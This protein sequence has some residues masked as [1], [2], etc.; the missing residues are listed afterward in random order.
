MKK[1]IW[2]IM[3]AG[4]FLSSCNRDPH[5][6]E[7]LF[8]PISL[9]TPQPF[10][11]SLYADTL[12]GVPVP[13]PYRWMEAEEAP[14]LQEWIQEESRRSTDY[15]SQIAFHEAVGQR[16][17]NLWNYERMSSPRKAG[18]F[19]YYFKN[20]GLQEQDLLYRQAL[21]GGAEEKVLDPGDFSNNGSTR[22]AQIA[23][24]AEGNYMAFELSDHGSDWRTIRVYDL[25]E[26]KLLNDTLSW[27]RYSNIAWSG[28]GFFYSRYPAPLRGEKTSTP[29][30]FHQVF[31]HRV[32][33][34][35]SA[36]Q[37]IF[38]DRAR[39]RR[40]FTPKTSQD[41]RY[42]VLN[43]WETHSGNGIYAMDLQRKDPEFIPI[44]DDMDHEFIFVGSTGSHLLFLT[45]FEADHRK[46]IQVS[47]AKPGPGY[48][49]DVIPEDADLLES[50]SMAGGRLVAHYL[51]DAQSYLRVFELDGSASNILTMPEMGTISDFQSQPNEDRAFFLFESFLTPPTV[52]DLD[53]QLLTARI[54]KSP[55]VNFNAGAYETRLVFFD[56]PDGVKLPLFITQKKG[57]K[58]NGSNPTLLTG[59]GS[60]NYRMTP[61]FDPSQL[62]FLENGGIL[63]HA[64]LRGGGEYGWK[65]YES[66]VRL[67]KQ[68]TFDDFRAA[69]EYLISQHYTKKEKLAIVGTGAG[70]LLVGVSITQHPEL[71][72]AA[73]AYSGIYD[74]IRYPL[75]TIGSKWAFDF[76]LSN[77]A[78]EFDYLFAYSPLHNVQP[79]AYPAVLLRTGDH[80]DFIYP[81]HTYKF[82]AELQAQLT[83]PLPVLLQVDPYAGSGTGKSTGD[84]IREE[85][86]LLCFLFFHLKQPVVYELK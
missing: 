53:L 73:V 57:T 46:L 31:F 44:V 35:Q 36:D 9:T 78:R 82:A 19:L 34:P 66:A 54:Y 25:L 60:F 42:L 3:A 85:T 13:D 17:R 75:F 77:Q 12:F 6:P 80:D 41:G 21:E 50:V 70:G 68:N 48:W 10:R 79:A 18:E 84:R 40:G 38:A 5:S 74:M 49:E 59:V 64:I 45:N 83:G 69:A 27:V 20:S 67:K 14:I 43:I 1:V 62:S 24:S 63:A 8:K 65:W 11:D 4:L 71:F 30:E 58:L 47:M 23:F 7:N 16:V 29:M 55:K 22:V 81:A 15:F 52:Y 32:G 86:D 37:L 28:N 2:G 61:R 33:T 76:G 72:Q 56:K 39:S 26:N 51:R